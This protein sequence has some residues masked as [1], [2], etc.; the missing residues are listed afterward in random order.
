MSQRAGLCKNSKKNAVGACW[1]YFW[2]SPH[3]GRDQLPNAFSKL[4]F[5]QQILFFF[6]LVL[7]ANFCCSERMCR[8]PFSGCAKNLIPNT[9]GKYARAKRRALKASEDF[10]FMMPRDVCTLVL[11]CACRHAA[12]SCF[13]TFFPRLN[14][15][16]IYS[17]EISA[18]YATFN[19]KLPAGISEVNCDFLFNFLTLMRLNLFCLFVSPFGAN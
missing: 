19:D 4:F 12:V 18:K 1:K 14:I 6:F 7:D 3:C 16:S 13:I 15:L 17:F 8:C 11:V 2:C 10:V 5:N 9:M